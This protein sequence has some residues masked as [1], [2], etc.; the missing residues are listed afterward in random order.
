[1]NQRWKFGAFAAFLVVDVV[2][3]GFMIR[4]LN[5][6]QKDAVSKAPST[7]T[8]TEAQKTEEPTGAVG[9]TTKGAG[10]T[11]IRSRR[12][13]CSN[14][15][16][17]LLEISRDG[18]QNFQEMAV[19]VLEEADATEPGSRPTSVRTVLHVEL[20][21]ADEFTIVAGDEK[22]K[23]HRYASED[24]GQ[25]WERKKGFEAWFVDAANSEIVS[26]NGV[27]NPGCK[28]ITALSQLSDVGAKVACSGGAIRATADSGATWATL[29]NL[30]NVKAAVFAGVRV[31]FAI[32]EGSKCLRSYSTED[33]GASWQA[34]GCVE[35][36]DVEDLAGTATH[37][38]V[39]DEKDVR[40]STDQGE[41]WKKP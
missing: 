17:P 13:S 31:G 8:T 37:L 11:L 16:R 23:P 14:T 25:T 27:L 1:M 2:L 5:D 38:V 20:E 15:G 4:E 29:G 21:S 26:S 28:Q 7:T 19:P 36:V 34:A 24:G 30:E 40:I 6:D 39:A 33:G 22:C 10:D 32:A 41:S 9:V 12:G 3:V 35:D 18:G